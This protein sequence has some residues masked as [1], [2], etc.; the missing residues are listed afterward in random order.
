MAA[1][2]SAISDGTTFCQR[3]MKPRSTM[4]ASPMTEVNPSKT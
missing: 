1:S 4:N 2:V 3:N